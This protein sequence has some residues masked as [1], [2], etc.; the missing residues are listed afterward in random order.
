MLQQGGPNTGSPSPACRGGETVSTIEKTAARPRPG[1]RECVRP[2]CQRTCTASWEIRR[3][4]GRREGLG[5]SG[6]MPRPQHEQDN[7]E[8]QEFSRRSS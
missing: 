5:C 3:E 4:L 1:P 2:R 8:V 7:P 6:L